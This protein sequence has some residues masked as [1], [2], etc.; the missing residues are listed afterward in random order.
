MIYAET[1]GVGK[2][3]NLLG[4]LRA[5]SR[6]RVEQAPGN[7][8]TSYNIFDADSGVKLGYLEIL[9]PDL[10]VFEVPENPLKEYQL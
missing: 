6:L 5:D 9:F 8:D 1:E 4:D 7:L 10:I 3:I 2:R